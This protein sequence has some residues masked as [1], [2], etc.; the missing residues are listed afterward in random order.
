MG[1][2]QSQAIVHLTCGQ[3]VGQ[4]LSWLTR[5]CDTINFFIMAIN[6]LNILHKLIMEH[7][8]DLTQVTHGIP[9]NLQTKEVM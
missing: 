9:N 6:I 3:V 7:T 1:S 2:V 5:Q 4:V 8:E